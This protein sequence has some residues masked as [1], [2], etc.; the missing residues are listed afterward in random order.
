M[1]RETRHS[2][3]RD[4]IYT[5]LAS[6][7]CHPS[8]EWLYTRLKDEYPKISLATVYRNL[9]LLCESG[10]A[11]R[12]DIG[13][14]TVRYDADTRDHH[15]FF[16]TSCRALSDFGSE[17]TAGIDHLLEKKY[18]VKID[19]HSFVFYGTCRECIKNKNQNS[20]P[21]GTKEKEK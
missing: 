8:A 10:K 11:I 15:H 2:R 16:C 19:F 7:T 18:G 13:D 20:D 4:A 1:Q 9:T 14:G 6:V 17:E 3:Q 21:N 5:L 12:L